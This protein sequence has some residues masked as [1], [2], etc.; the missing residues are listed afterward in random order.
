MVIAL[1]SI[2]N[3]S[4]WCTV[5]WLYISVFHWESQKCVKIFYIYSLLR[6]NKCLRYIY[7]AWLNVMQ[8]SRTW[9]Y[10]PV[11]S[12]LRSPKISWFSLNLM[13]ISLSTHLITHH[14]YMY[15]NKY[16]YVYTYIKYQCFMSFKKKRIILA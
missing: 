7:L 10:I 9:W 4:F 12:T 6:N 11:V 2:N 14:L 1:W 16:V 8:W 5:R 3:G 15:M 13:T